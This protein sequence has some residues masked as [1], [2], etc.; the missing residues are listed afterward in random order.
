[1]ELAENPKRVG[2]SLNSIIMKKS[3]S[4]PFLV[5]LLCF[6]STKGNAQYK[7]SR[8]YVVTAH[9][10]VCD[11]NKPVKMPVVSNVIHNECEYNSSSDVSVQF[12]NYWGSMYRSLGS[13]CSSVTSVV[14][15]S[16]QTKG[17]AE[18]ARLKFISDYNSK[19]SAGKKQETIIANRFSFYCD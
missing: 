16:Y 5:L 17:A 18:K 2:K 6:F 1:M 19:Y 8:Y 13:N 4:I 14:A 12:S 15:H 10:S 11:N 3:I 9:E 7:Q